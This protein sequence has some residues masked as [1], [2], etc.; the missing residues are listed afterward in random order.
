MWC[1]LDMT[2]SKSWCKT[3]K[4][5]NSLSYYTAWTLN[6]ERILSL[7]QNQQEVLP[8]G[9]DL[10]MVM[11]PYGLGH[12][13][14]RLVAIGILNIGTMISHGIE[15]VCPLKWSKG[16]LIMKSMATVIPLVEFDICLLD[17]EYI[18]WSHNKWDL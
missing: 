8:Y 13:W 9:W 3:I 4:C 17:L 14:W 1:I 11:Y 12:Y 10:K 16:H 6:L 7:G 15:T 18:N 5:H 2:Y